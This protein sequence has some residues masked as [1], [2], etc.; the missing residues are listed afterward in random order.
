MR[1]L[2]LLSWT[3]SVLLITSLP[4][5]ADGDPARGEEIFEEQCSVC[6][7]IGVDAENLVGPVLT[8]VIGRT[9]GT[10]EEFEY[11]DSTIE[12]GEKGLVW[13]EEKIFS[14]LADPSRFL[15]DFLDDEDA[16]SNMGFQLEEEQDRLDLIAYVA[17]F[18]DQE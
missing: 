2:L 10:Y 8:N 9:A 3:V 11:G 16:E 4:A 12:A 14:Y 15:S 7:Q 17:T 6:H 18:R 13:D 1:A 5:R